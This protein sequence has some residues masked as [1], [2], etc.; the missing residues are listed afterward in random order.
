MRMAQSAPQ[1]TDGAT[2]SLLGGLPDAWEIERAIETDAETANDV[3]RELLLEHATGAALFIKG[4]TLR[5]FTTYYRKPSEEI[6]GTVLKSRLWGRRRIR[7]FEQCLDRGV[8][9]ATRYDS[10]RDT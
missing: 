10:T 3:H 5:G 9:L 2:N 7:S 1:F 8:L 4:S 6:F